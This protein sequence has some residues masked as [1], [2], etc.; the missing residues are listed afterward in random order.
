MRTYFVALATLVVTGVATSASAET[1][2]FREPHHKQ[3]IYTNFLRAFEVDLAPGETMA[4]HVHQF[5]VATLILGDATTVTTV[6]GQAG[7]P[8][9]AATGTVVIEP[10]AIAP[11]A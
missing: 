4:D 7:A 10:P 5:D 3:L 2:A 8:V 11:A 1:P 6:G 9:T